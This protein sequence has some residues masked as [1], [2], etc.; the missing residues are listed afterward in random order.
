MFPRIEIPGI[1]SVATWDVLA[2]LALLVAYA[3]LVSRARASGV[4][5]HRAAELFLASMVLSVAGGWAGGMLWGARDSVTVTSGLS[6][7][8]ALV[9]GAPLV[10][11]VLWLRGGDVLR[12]LELGT[13]SL[14]LALAVMRLGC[15]ANGCCGGRPTELA[16]AVPQPPPVPGTWV[17]GH[18]VQL[19]EAVLMFALWRGL[20][21]LHG[22]RPAP[23]VV[24]ATAL[25]ALGGTRFGLEWLRADWRPGGPLP[26]LSWAQHV[27][28]AL[29]SAGALAWGASVRAPRPGPEPS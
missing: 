12:L 3:D 22:R 16:W 5:E 29:A 27:C 8:G 14:A 23:F 11:A 1:A 21:A 20:D 15:W 2:C 28:L 4:H 26:G 7:L 24:A 10:A 6:F 19:I 25:V 18:P 17:A 13:G 9:F